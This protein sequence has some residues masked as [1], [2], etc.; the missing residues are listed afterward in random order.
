MDFAPPT[1]YPGQE[2]PPPAEAPPVDDGKPMTAAQKL[3]ALKAKLADARKT[4]HK[5][6]V[7]EDRRNKLGPQGLKDE[8]KQKRYD[9]LAK[10]G[11]KE[12]DTQKLMATTAATAQAE[13]E[14]AEKKAR[15]R[16]EYGWD[17]FNNE[18]QHR[19]YKKRIRRA[20]EEGRVGQEEDDGADPDPLA[21][22]Q[23]PPVAQAKLAALAD[24][25]N[26]AA[27]RNAQFSRRR[28]FDEDKDVTY[29]NRRNEVF[30]KKIERAFDSYTAEIRQNLERGTAL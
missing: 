30:N 25:M 28:T 8:A 22:G 21:Y 16:G 24:D 29:I 4:N 9:Q 17:V 23:A 15:R 5:A 1:M 6:V 19:H 13:Q 27:L 11:K 18:A 10:D 26:E 2:E 7:E 14:K 3:A 20:E 12:T